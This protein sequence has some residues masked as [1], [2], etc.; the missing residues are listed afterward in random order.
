M[1]R[2]CKWCG[3]DTE[4]VR[5]RLCVSCKDMRTNYN[6]RIGRMFHTTSVGDLVRFRNLCM[7]L[8]NLK[9]HGGEGLP[10]DLDYQLERVNRYLADKEKGPS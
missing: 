1:T 6:Y 7:D 3:E 5:K 4:S 9:E 8:Q 2:A 10:G